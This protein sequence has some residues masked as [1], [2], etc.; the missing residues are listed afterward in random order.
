MYVRLTDL[1]YTQ[2]PRFIARQE[3]KPDSVGLLSLVATDTGDH[4]S[5][6]LFRLVLLFILRVRSADVAWESA[7]GEDEAQW[8][9]SPA[10]RCSH[11]AAPPPPLRPRLCLLPVRDAGGCPSHCSGGGLAAVAYTRG[12]EEHP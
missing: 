6:I 1:V 7:A 5:V 8:V 9:Q 3:E 2:F 10:S 12:E 4:A 11:A